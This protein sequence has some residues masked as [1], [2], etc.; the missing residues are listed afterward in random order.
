[1]PQGVAV[2]TDHFVIS[3]QRLYGI[4]SNSGHESDSVLDDIAGEVL[5]AVDALGMT[6]ALVKS[7]MGGCSCASVV[8]SITTSVKPGKV[9]RR[10]AA[11]DARLSLV[12]GSD[13]LVE[14]NLGFLD[15][16]RDGLKGFPLYPV[17]LLL[18]GEP[19]LL[20]S[21]DSAHRPTDDLERPGR[22]EAGL[23]LLAGLGLHAASRS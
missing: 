9:A 22:Y 6:V 8:P 1:L 17:L 13:E 2:P 23:A 16:L 10:L 3:F 19:R 15:Q 4:Q 21:L 12:S 5:V 11:R 18:G 14:F 7:E 20:G